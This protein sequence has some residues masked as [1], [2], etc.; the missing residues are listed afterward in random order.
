MTWAEILGDYQELGILE[1]CSKVRVGLRQFKGDAKKHKERE[2]IY[3]YQPPNDAE[4]NQK[5]QGPTTHEQGAGTSGNPK[6]RTMKGSGRET[7][8]LIEMNQLTWEK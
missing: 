7:F 4:R 8:N 6:K 5:A 2:Q 1:T 3:P